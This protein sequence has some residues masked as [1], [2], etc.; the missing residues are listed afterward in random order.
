MVLPAVALLLPL[1]TAAGI[2][3]AGFIRGADLSYLQQIEDAGGVFRDAGRPQD[4]LEIF[5]R[6]GFNYVRLRL[7]HTAP[8]AYNGLGK[9]LQ[10]ALRIKQKKMKFLLDFHY[11]GTWA[12][13]GHQAPPPEWAGLP[14]SVLRDSMYQYTFSVIAAL[15]AQQTPPDMVQLGNEIS[16][17]L[18][19]DAGNVCGSFNTPAQWDQLAGL[20]SDARRAVHD[21]LSPSDS[22]LIMIHTDR[23]ADPGGAIWFFDSLTARGVAFDI[24]GLSYYPWWHTRDLGVLTRTL[25]T[26]A[27][28]YHKDILIAETA[29]PWTLASQDTVF[30]Q[31]GSTGQIIDQFP[32]TVE[33]QEGFLD[34][35]MHIV[36]DIPENLGV[37]ICYWAPDH[38]VAPAFGS[39]WENLAL[40]DFGG[41]ALASFAAFEPQMEIGYPPGWNL[42][43]VPYVPGSAEAGSV[44]PQPGALLFAYSGS[45]EPTD[46]VT[47]GQAYWIYLADSGT[48]LFHGRYVAGDTITVN[49]NWNLIGTGDLPVAAAGIIPVPPV[50]ITSGVFGLTSGS[51]GY[52]VADTLEPGRG[53]WLRVSAAGKIVLNSPR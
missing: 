22:A 1:T 48:V 9:T 18:L 12:D 23:S 27:G 28:R 6:H 24:I 40:F 42:V 32:A 34:T 44:F 45:Y 11:S 52:S 14:Y 21:A 3:P 47:T 29:Y 31:V 43:S 30:N 16:C 10:M 8:G 41:N 46:T 15:K 25:D 7:W 2:L 38:I 5:R 53:Y 50:V 13:P 20:L 26:L 4:A 19:W 37:G 17:G 39:D 35:L 51:A 36:A 33:G 49:R